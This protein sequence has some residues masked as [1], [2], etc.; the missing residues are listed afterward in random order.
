[1]QIQHLSCSPAK[2]FDYFV[3]FQQLFFR[4]L[5]QEHFC[6]LQK[7]DLVAAV[8]DVEACPVRPCPG[9]R[10]QGLANLAEHLSVVVSLSSLAREVMVHLIELAVPKARKL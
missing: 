4:H 1:M 10:G 6:S 3:V 9:W 7:M 8:S 5:H 2:M